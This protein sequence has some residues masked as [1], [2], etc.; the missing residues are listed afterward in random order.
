MDEKTIY[1]KDWAPWGSLD[2]VFGLGGLNLPRGGVVRSNWRFVLF[3]LI[4]TALLYF[5]VILFKIMKL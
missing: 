5:V 3:F 2:C 1:W 4:G